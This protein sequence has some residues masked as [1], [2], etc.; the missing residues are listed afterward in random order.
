MLFHCLLSQRPRPLVLLVLASLIAFGSAADSSAAGG[1]AS[2]GW[3]GYRVL[4]RPDEEEECRMLS[5]VGDSLWVEY[6]V[7]IDEASQGKNKLE[8]KLG[9]APVSG[10]DDHLVGMCI[11]E[12]REL[13]IPPS[14]H[15][16][17]NIG[18]NDNVPKD[19]VL[20]FQIRLLDINGTVRKA[21]HAREKARAENAKRRAGKRR[22]AAEL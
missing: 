8:F 2:G 15:G 5:V 11:D 19:A 20:Q 1:G 4:D 9:S 18:M 6:E 22:A 10:W 16:H 17:N 12:Q 21:G 13:T 3:V 14:T 7:F